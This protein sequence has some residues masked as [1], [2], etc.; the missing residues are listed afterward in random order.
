MSRKKIDISQIDLNKIGGRFA[1]VRLFYGQD[2][3]V[4]ANNI[5]LS[6]SNV[7]NIENHKYDPSFKPLKN[8][9][10]IYKVN[11]IWLLTGEGEPY[12]VVMLEDERL[13]LKN[14]GTP[15]EEYSEDFAMQLEV[16]T[17]EEAERRKKDATYPIYD[18]DQSN[19]SIVSTPSIPYNQQPAADPARDLLNKARLILASKSE[20]SSSL[21]A[22]IE[23]SYKSLD[24][25]RRT[26]M[27]E[28]KN[29]TLEEKCDKILTDLDDIKR[30]LDNMSSPHLEGA[31]EENI[32]KK[33][34]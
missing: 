25:D 1:Y 30:R 14:D 20:Y 22:H 2:Q 31:R 6:I 26:S 12:K 5:G 24:L 18:I 32:E 17:R 15:V 16:I 28:N 11:P 19:S 3:E 4:F 10:E 23:S 7:S 21:I 29:K 8:L 13:F 33:A 34:M 9:I 27:L